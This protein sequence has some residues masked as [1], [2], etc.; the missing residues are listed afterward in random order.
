MASAL[1]FAR[2][3]GPLTRPPALV[4][5]IADKSGLLCSRLSASAL[6]VRTGFA[7]SGDAF[8]K[9]TS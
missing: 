6:P 1:F 8:L 7:R 2:K 3:S 4:L 9:G 5:Y